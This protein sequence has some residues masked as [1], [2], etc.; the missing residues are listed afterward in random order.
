M[1]SAALP[2]PEVD[3][4]AAV[5][6]RA[7]ED[8]VTPDDRLARPRTFATP[9]GPRRTFTVGIRP[10][11]REEAVRFLLDGAPGWAGAR[12]AWCEAAGV[13]PDAIRRYALRHVPPGSIPT[14]V[15]RGPLPS[16]RAAD[17]A[18]PPILSEVALRDS[19]RGGLR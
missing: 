15:R 3:L 17:D 16:P 6:H 1:L 11:D 14:D 7:L 8:A 9:A 10:R 5:I 19:P 18:P 13:D 4:A 12:A 2:I